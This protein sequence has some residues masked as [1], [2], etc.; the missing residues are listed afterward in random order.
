[1]QLLTQNK[2]ELHTVVLTVPYVFTAVIFAG[3]LMCSKRMK[4]KEQLRP[5]IISRES[6]KNPV[7][8]SAL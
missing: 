8:Y 3:Y 2:T 5:Q 4:G 7:L 1:M 6:P